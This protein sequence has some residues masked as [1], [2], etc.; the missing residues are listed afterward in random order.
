MLIIV[1][2]LLQARIWLGD[3]SLTFIHR[4]E[5][6]VAIL[7]RRNMALH[8]ENDR[9]QQR[10]NSIKTDVS[11]IEERARSELMMISKDELLLIIKD[12]SSEQ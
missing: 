12:L 4:L 9:L 6:Q 2:L 5:H 3:G 10:I 8:V 7:Q 11:A 1:L